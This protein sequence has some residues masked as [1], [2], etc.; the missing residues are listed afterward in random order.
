MLSRENNQI[1]ARHPVSSETTAA[2]WGQVVRA[3][4]TSW[5]RLHRRIAY[6]SPLNATHES[7]YDQDVNIEIGPPTDNHVK[8][9]QKWTKSDSSEPVPV[10]V[11][12]HNRELF[13]CV[14]QAYQNLPNFWEPSPSEI[15]ENN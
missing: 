9:G 10:K 13:L 14:W 3:G 12:C 4:V 11:T 8:N 6:T 1:S 2:A 15:E 7:P 5:C